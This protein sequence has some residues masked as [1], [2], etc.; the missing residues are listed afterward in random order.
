MAA[1]G[2]PRQ[3][4]NKHETVTRILWSMNG[5][6]FTAREIVG[7]AGKQDRK[8]PISYV[9]QYLRQHRHAGCIRISEKPGD[10]KT[11][12]YQVVSKPAFRE[13]DGAVANAVWCALLLAKACPKPR[14]W[15]ISA[16]NNGRPVKFQEGSIDRVLKRL[17]DQGD[18]EKTPLGYRITRPYSERPAITG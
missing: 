10:G 6:E 5:S 17:T 16:A 12:L 1:K 18:I 11:N 15:V 2:I 9:K 4:S 14:C 7:I 13:P 8:I 3:P